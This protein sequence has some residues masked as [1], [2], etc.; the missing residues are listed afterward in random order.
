M[1]IK[2]RA[3]R[4]RGS[5]LNPKTTAA[6]ADSRLDTPASA[7][8]PALTPKP[9][10]VLPGHKKTQTPISTTELAA[11]AILKATIFEMAAQGPAAATGAGD[12]P[13]EEPAKVRGRGRVS[14]RG[15]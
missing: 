6:A 9:A 8:A 4:N 2:G 12:G 7:P 10:A 15:V 11:T 3:R 14:A 13:S 1:G 5:K